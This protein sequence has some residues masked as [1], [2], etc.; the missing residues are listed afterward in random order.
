MTDPA[1]LFTPGH[2]AGRLVV[3]TVGLWAAAQ[4][5]ARRT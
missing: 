3:V 4:G 5:L 1:D 2:P